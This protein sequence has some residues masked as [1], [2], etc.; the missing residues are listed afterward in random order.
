MSRYPH[1]TSCANSLHLPAAELM[2]A[3]GEGVFLHG[4][5]G[6]HRVRLCRLHRQADPAQEPSHHHYMINIPTLLNAEQ[7]IINCL[8]Y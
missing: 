6:A 1:Y 3:W 8:R 2:F 7:I 5:R 4:L